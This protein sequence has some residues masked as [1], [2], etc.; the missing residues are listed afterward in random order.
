VKNSKRRRSQKRPQGKGSL[1]E[2][3]VNALKA[4]PRQQQRVPICDVEELHARIRAFVAGSLVIGEAVEAIARLLHWHNR[5]EGREALPFDV[6]ES[7]LADAGTIVNLVA[8]AI[9]APTPEHWE[10]IRRWRA[11]AISVTDRRAFV[12]QQVKLAIELWDDGH[13]RDAL[14]VVRLLCLADSRFITVTER[15][16]MRTLD[17]RDGRTEAPRIAARL[18]VASG[19]FGDNDERRARAAFYAASP[20]KKRVKSS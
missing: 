19:A 2:R 17:E 16:A 8:E 5:R 13:H 6:T 12:V 10:T 11:D 7:D 14:G 4:Q 15:E 18:A 1:S 3:V 20:K 9:I